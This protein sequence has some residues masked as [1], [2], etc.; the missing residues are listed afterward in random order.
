MKYMWLNF[1]QR[2]QSRML[3]WTPCDVI[4]M[5]TNW[6]NGRSNFLHGSMLHMVSSMPSLLLTSCFAKIGA[7]MNAMKVAINNL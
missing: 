7:S 1:L 2:R 4:R 3:G 6:G 5:Q